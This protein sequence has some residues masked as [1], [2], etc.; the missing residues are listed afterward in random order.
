MKL[1]FLPRGITFR[2]ANSQTEPKFWTSSRR[3]ELMKIFPGNQD[4]EQRGSF[5]VLAC[6]IT[7]THIVYR[8]WSPGHAKQLDAPEL[9]SQ[10]WAHI[11]MCCRHRPLIY[12]QAKHAW[13]YRRHW[14]HSQNSWHLHWET[15]ITGAAEGKLPVGYCPELLWLTDRARG[16]MG[17]HQWLKQDKTFF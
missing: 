11:Q 9:R 14:G 17:V 15:A 2:K 16:L 6:P 4:K 5:D 13:A 3:K 10:C 1:I 7:L 12:Q 8:A